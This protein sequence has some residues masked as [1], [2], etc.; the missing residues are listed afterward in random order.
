M[1]LLFFIL[2][3]WHSIFSG[4]TFALLFYKCL[5][6]CRYIC[7]GHKLDPVSSVW[8]W[9]S[10]I[11]CYKG[12]S[13]LKLLWKFA[14]QKCQNNTVVFQPTVESADVMC[15]SLKLM[16]GV[17]KIRMTVWHW[18]KVFSQQ[19]VFVEQ[20]TQHLVPTFLPPP[21]TLRLVDGI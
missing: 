9:N 12:V 8:R 4:G 15:D 13:A 3:I 5:Q 19:Q 2:K 18:A 14:L 1:L 16:E 17:F 10:S 21:K 7:P 11:V 6:L 20:L